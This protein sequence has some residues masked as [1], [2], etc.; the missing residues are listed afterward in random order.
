MGN[1]FSNLPIPV[2]DGPGTAVNVSAQGEEKTIVVEGDFVGSTLA[3]EAATDAAGTNFAPVALFDANGSKKVKVAAR[4][5]RTNVQGRSAEPFSVVCDVG[6]NDNATQV[7]NLPVPAGDG[8]GAS[9]D[10]SALGTFNTFIAGGAFR[11]VT[12]TIQVS[13]D[14]SNWVPIAT[15]TAGSPLVSLP[16][17]ANYMR[18]FVR[19]RTGNTFPFTV[20]VDVG[21][22]NDPASITAASDGLQSH[23]TYKPGG[24]GVGPVEYDSWAALEA[25]KEAMRAAGGGEGTFVIT[26]DDSITNPA[27]IPA[28]GPYNLKDCILRGQDRVTEL[29]LA[30]GSSATGFRHIGLNLAIQNRTTGSS[31]DS[32]LDD[33]DVIFIED[34]SVITCKNGS[35]SIWDASGLTAGQAISIFT[36]NAAAIGGGGTSRGPIVDGFVSGTICVLAM[37]QGGSMQPEV[38][39]GAAGALLLIRLNTA[40]QWAE[41]T[42]WLGTELAGTL[43]TPASFYPNPFRAAIATAAVTLVFGDWGRYD[44]TGGA[45]PQTLPKISTAA[46]SRRGPGAIVVM[47]EEGG[48]AGLTAVPDAGDTINGGAGA[49]AIPANGTVIFTSDGTSD[50]RAIVVYDPAAA[51]AAEAH[52]WAAPATAHARDDEFEATTLDGAW[53]VSPIVPVATAIDPYATHVGALGPRQEIHTTRR[54]SWLMTQVSDDGNHN[55]WHQAWT[56]PTNL[57]MWARMSFNHRVDSSVLDDAELGIAMSGT[58]SGAPDENNLVQMYLNRS[59]AAAN[60]RARA[61]VREAGTEFFINQGFDIYATEIHPATYEY[62]GIQKLAGLYHFW[63]AGPG[64]EWHHLGSYTYAGTPTIDRVGFFFRNSSSAAPG[65]MIMG[66]DFVRFVESAVYL[67]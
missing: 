16:V 64:M 42:N 21:A 59:V 51:S 23:F 4:W 67:P 20:T 10:V 32:S 46:S 47:S 2:S 5:L 48:A 19:G 49:F 65:N 33:L 61:S 44:V 39:A 31:F 22:S 53:T 25:A 24:G 35:T 45:V 62:V 28:G 13:N 58:S 26:I 27:V 30:D 11:D 54:R 1:V 41:Q 34:A 8:A 55:W 56:L 50:W 3:I 63:A 38:L 6:A 40:H 17:T 15:L 12:L 7:L 60:V 29:D 36:S 37:G 18:V 14:N 57:F 43:Y 9:V 52:I 66:I